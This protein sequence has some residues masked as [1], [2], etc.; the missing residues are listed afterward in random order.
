M[1]AITVSHALTLHSLRIILLLTGKPNKVNK[2]SPL[3]VE[4]SANI[5]LTQIKPPPRKPAVT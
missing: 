3:R 5:L 2:L 1:Q 4:T